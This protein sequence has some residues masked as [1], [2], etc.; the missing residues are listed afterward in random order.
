MAAS[1]EVEVDLTSCAICFETFNSPKYLPCLHSF[2]EGC[3][4]TYIDSAFQVNSASNGINCPVCRTFVPKPDNIEADKWAKEFPSNHLLVSIIDL[5]KAKAESRCCNACERDGES[6]NATSWCVNCVESLC[7]ACVRYHRRHKQSSQHKVID[8]GDIKGIESPIQ[9]TDIYCREHPEEKLK[10]FCHDHSV[11]CCMTCI[12]L[13]HRKCD[14]VQSVEKAAKSKKKSKELTN[15]EETFTDMKTQ[16]EKL[17]EIKVENT[18]DCEKSI[19]DIKLEIN[20]LCD[21]FIKHVGQLRDKALHEVSAAEKE[22]LPN[23]ESERD[24]L[25]CKISAIENDIQLLHTNTKFAQPAQYL[26]AME[27]L[28]QQ[29]QILDIYIK[30]KARSIENVRISFRPSEKISEITKSLVTFGTVSV[31]REMH[32]TTQKSAKETT[33]TCSDMLSRTPTLVRDANISGNSITCATFLQ[34][35]HILISKYQSELLELWDDDCKLLSSLALPGPPCRIKMTSPTEG[36]VVIWKTVLLYFKINSNNISEVRRVQVPVTCDFHYHNGRYYIGSNYKIIVQDSNHQHVRGIAVDGTVGYMA[37]RDDDTL[38]YTKFRGFVLHCI[39]L[40]GTPVF[41]YSHDKLKG[42]MGVTVDCAS[43]IY[44]C[45]YDSRNVHQLSRDGQLQRILF[46]NL[47]AN[48]YCISFSKDHD[49]AVIG[50][51]S[52][53]LL[54]K[55][56]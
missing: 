7:E 33:V 32:S 20:Q 54:Y 51:G 6:V 34:D 56:T 42:T 15:L 30:D 25:K 31:D 53:M 27:K 5:N 48:P 23:L 10:A 26:Q 14:N 1:K 12:M 3:L 13:S 22:M 43:N 19:S 16:L 4:L 44:V 2:C 35:G 8:I 9:E 47:P 18:T 24:E 21:N 36:I 52:R 49:K 41:Q 45:G 29:S 46:D 50:C 37:A 17:V 55:L 11:V 39:T 38:C 28:K 40:D